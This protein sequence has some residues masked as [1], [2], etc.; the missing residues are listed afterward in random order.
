MSRCNG[1]RVRQRVGK[2][3]LIT[4]LFAAGPPALA[5][6]PGRSSPTAAVSVGTT[7]NAEL[8]L[9]SS[10]A[11]IGTAIGDY[12]MLNVNGQPVRLS[13]FRGK[14]LVL[15]FIYTGCFQIC[16]TTTRTL[17]RAVAAAQSTF[18]PEAF[19]V[20]SVGFNVPFD[21][22]DAMRAF[23]RQ[24][25]VTVPG[26]E[27]LSPDLLTLERLARDVGF[28]FAPS[29]RGFDHLIQITV[30]D[31]KGRVYR[32]I[33]AEDFALPQLMQPLKELIIGAPREQ[34]TL[35]G[36]LARVRI[37]CTVYDPASGTYRF[38]YSVLF[39]LTGGLI[40]LS[41]TAW[42]FVHELRRTRAAASQLDRGF[43]NPD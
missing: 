11:A 32:Q 20:A 21:T 27:F 8:A 10:Q 23:A 41:L 40:G 24:Q 15:N 14:P 2:L 16:P 37:L 39:E 22:P 36:F 7:L 9:K 42:F 26:W 43:L 33:Y 5:D 12:T 1:P 31:A 35:S 29:P 25:G 34:E 13:S 38:K 30:I 4:L 6:D 18:G 28:S 19:H 17:K 3:A